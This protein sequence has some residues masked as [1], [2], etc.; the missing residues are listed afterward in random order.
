MPGKQIKGPALSAEF[1]GVSY[2]MPTDLE[3]IGEKLCC[4]LRKRL[5]NAFYKILKVL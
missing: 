3:V 4:C 2:H 1:V 5:I